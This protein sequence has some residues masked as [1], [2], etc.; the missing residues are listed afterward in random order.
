MS[1]GCGC[2]LEAAIGNEQ[3]SML[4]SSL[5]LLLVLSSQLGAYPGFDLITGLPQ[6]RWCSRWW[7]SGSCWPIPSGTHTA[8][9]TVSKR[10]RT[11]PG[12][13]R[14]GSARKLSHVTNLLSKRGIFVQFCW[15][16]CSKTNKFQCY[17]YH[18]MIRILPEEPNSKHVN[19]PARLVN[20]YCRAWD[21]PR[22][23][24][25]GPVLQGF[26]GI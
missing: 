9:C 4:W 26:G 25:K 21:D 8:C 13:D 12:R 2:T 3:A 20:G 15:T 10:W 11:K 16:R 6:G 7:Y 5:R 22:N 1:S 19:S 14:N 17:Q 24:T 23:A 18:T